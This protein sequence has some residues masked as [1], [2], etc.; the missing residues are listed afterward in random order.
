MFD[1]HTYFITYALSSH[2]PKM[3]EAVTVGNVQEACPGVWL[4]SVSISLP[5]GGIF[6]SRHSVED[7]LKELTNDLENKDLFYLR[8]S[9]VA[10]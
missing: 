10:K 6:P 1:L 8:A 7:L 9:E 2:S 5:H 3:F 4:G